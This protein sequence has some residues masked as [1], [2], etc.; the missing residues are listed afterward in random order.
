MAD[1][2]NIP[3][4]KLHINCRILPENI[5]CKIK[6]RNNIRRTNTCD[7]ALKLLNEEI[8]SDMQKH[9]PNIWK[10]HLDALWDHMHNTHILCKT[11]HSLSNRAPPTTHNNSIN[12]QQ[13]NSKQTQTYCEL[14][15][16]T[17]HKHRQ[18]RNTQ[19]KRIH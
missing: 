13:Q 3:K 12:L 5:V 18:T 17:I 4:G 9:K 14:F 7:P 10:K 19:N 6:Q 16:H 15:H 2:H 8:T 1:K 11:I